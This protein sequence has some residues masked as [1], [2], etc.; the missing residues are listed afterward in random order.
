MVTE[1][2][3]TT[4]EVSRTL[5]TME[6]AVT[7]TITTKM[8][9]G[10]RKEVG[11]EEVGGAGEEEVEEDKD[12]EEAGEGEGVK[13][14]IKEDSLNSSSNMVVSTTTKLALTKADT[15]LV[16]DTVRGIAAESIQSLTA[17]HAG[18]DFKCL[19]I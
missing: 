5:A 1:Q 10:I 6:E 2:E 7:M 16:E 19:I 3:G 11:F 4:K 9:A 13:I 14:L 8:E 15:T 12:K 18:I 17:Y